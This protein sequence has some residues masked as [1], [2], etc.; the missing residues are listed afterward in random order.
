MLKVARAKAAA[1]AQPATCADRPPENP[2]RI[3]RLTAGEAVHQT[4]P[5]TDGVILLGRDGNPGIRL[6]HT[7]VTFRQFL[8]PSSETEWSR[9]LAEQAVS[10]HADAARAGVVVR[11][12]Q[13]AG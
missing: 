9:P 5:A 2:A 12:E 13:P 4:R 7:A 8:L 6:Q 1:S 3:E 10:L 11:L